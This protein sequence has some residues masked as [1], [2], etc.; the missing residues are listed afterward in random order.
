MNPHGCGSS[1]DSGQAWHQTCRDVDD[2]E[3]GDIDFMLENIDYSKN[4]INN[5]VFWT[6]MKRDIAMRTLRNIFII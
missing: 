5:T 2:M 1:S 4:L 3:P 6:N